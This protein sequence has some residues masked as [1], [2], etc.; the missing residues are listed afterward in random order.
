MPYPQMAT[1]TRLPGLSWSA[2]GRRSPDQA[3]PVSQQRMAR[4]GRESLGPQIPPGLVQEGLLKVFPEI[5]SAVIL[6]VWQGEDRQGS[7]HRESPA[8]ERAATGSTAL[9]RRPS[10]GWR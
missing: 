9:R 10:S 8:R 1:G 6:R 3:E 7:A 4:P 5:L 2:P